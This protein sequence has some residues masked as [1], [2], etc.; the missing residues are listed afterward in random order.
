MPGSFSSAADS[1]ISQ[2]ALAVRQ[3]DPIRAL[4]ANAGLLGAP[5]RV[6]PEQLIGKGASSAYFLLSFLVARTRQAKDWWHDVIVGQLGAGNFA[7]EYHHIHPRATLAGEYSKGEI[8]DLANLAFIS[9]KANKKISDRSPSDYFPELYDPAAD[10]DQ[11]SAHLVPTDPVL[12]T[13]DRYHEFI[14]ARRQLL[15]SAMTELL[16]T[17]RPAWVEGVAEKPEAARSEQS[18]AMTL[19]APPWEALVFEATAGG[20]RYVTSLPIDELERFVA[21]AGNGLASSLMLGGEVVEH[22]PNAEELQLPVGPFLVTGRTEDW[23][24]VL[25]RERGD[26]AVPYGGTPP[27]EPPWT[28]GREL[29]SVLDSD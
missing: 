23:R 15:A 28:G 7:L 16:D 17:R 11:L 8:N 10:K 27:T 19:Y 14:S 6:T 3:P 9:A 4:F 2:D 12:R 26:V 22:A 24:T 1:K 25:A 13:A 5:L 20:E 29:F 18:L 21:D